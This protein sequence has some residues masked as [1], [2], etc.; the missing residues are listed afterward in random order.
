MLE[1]LILYNGSKA[2]NFGSLI[3][4]YSASPTWITKL[5]EFSLSDSELRDY[6]ALLSGF[7]LSTCK[8]ELLCFYWIEFSEFTMP[9]YFLTK[10][11]NDFLTEEWEL[12]SDSQILSFWTLDVTW[13]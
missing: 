5:A 13:F 4:F 12:D 1:F 9:G 2:S 11:E 7:W 8:L 6:E 10:S 3:T